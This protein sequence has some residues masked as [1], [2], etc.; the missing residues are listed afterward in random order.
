MLVLMNPINLTISHQM[1]TDI[2]ILFL[3]LYS[4]VLIK[5]ENLARKEMTFGL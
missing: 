5:L 2:E 1:D 4:Y 3:S